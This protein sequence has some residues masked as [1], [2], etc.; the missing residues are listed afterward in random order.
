L[1]VLPSDNRSGIPGNTTRISALKNKIKCYWLNMQIRWVVNGTIDCIK[2]LVTTG[3]SLLF[4]GRPGV[5]K[6][7]K[8]REIARLLS[9]DLGMRVIIVDTSNE[10]AGV[11]DIPHPAIGRAEECRFIS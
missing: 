6:T 5:G 3:K 8:L 11:G 7:T 1:K 4:L 10:I 9:E 2:D